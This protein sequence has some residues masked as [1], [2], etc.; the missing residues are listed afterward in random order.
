MVT[1]NS[2]RVE[3]DEVV[4]DVA[5]FG[6]SAEILGTVTGDVA[7]FGGSAHLH[8]GAVV[9]GD[10]TTL[11]ARSGSTTARASTGTWPRWAATSIAPTA[12]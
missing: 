10:A 11:G 1:G 9:E 3:K 8:D 5:V 4:H 7:V 6:G 12:R 2:V